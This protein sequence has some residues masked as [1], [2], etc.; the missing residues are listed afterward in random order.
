[1]KKNKVSLLSILQVVIHILAVSRYYTFP[2]MDSE[3]SP[4]KRLASEANLS[5]AGAKRLR[6]SA[7]LSDA[8]ARRL[9]RLVFEADLSNAA[10]SDAADVIVTIITSSV[11]GGEGYGPSTATLL[12]RGLSLKDRRELDRI[13]G[14]QAAAC[15]LDVHGESTAAETT[16]YGYA[17]TA[18]GLWLALV[19]ALVT[20]L[21]E[22]PSAGTERYGPYTLYVPSDEVD[23]TYPNPD[24]E[25]DP[26][27]SLEGLAE[28]LKKASL[29]TNPKAPIESFDLAKWA[30]IL[31]MQVCS[32]CCTRNAYRFTFTGS[33]RRGR[34]A[35]LRCWRGPRRITCVYPT[36]Q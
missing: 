13:I 18:Y 16:A 9:R 35:P 32:T 17:D 27:V 24:N 29:H 31:Q 7:S 36:L 33:A 25:D 28:I 10:A 14:A 34:R 21:T 11:Y 2:A 8:D 6:R 15:A 23:G 4:T 22:K 3:R 1:M 5:D 20:A 30:G 12:L 26:R 19:R